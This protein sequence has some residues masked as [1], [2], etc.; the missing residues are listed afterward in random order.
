MQLY[1]TK[2]LLYSEGNHQ[3]NIKAIYWMGENICNHS[4]DNGL[5]SEVD[6]ELK[7]FNSKRIQL[8]MGKVTEYTIFFPKKSYR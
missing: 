8:K 2:N 6:K 1:K 5:I 3:Q 7:Q 4:A